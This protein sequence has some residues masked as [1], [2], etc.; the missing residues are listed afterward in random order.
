MQEVERL[1]QSRQVLVGEGGAHVQNERIRFFQRRRP[2]A[3]RGERRLG[4][5]Q[6]E[7]DLPGCERL[8]GGQIAGDELGTDNYPARFDMRPPEKQPVQR[9][10]QFVYQQRCCPFPD[11]PEHG[12]VVGGRD[13]PAEVGQGLLGHGEVDEIGT[14]PIEHP[15]ESQLVQGIERKLGEGAGEGMKIRARGLPRVVGLQQNRI[16]VF[17]VN[18]LQVFYEAVGVPSGTRTPDAG[19]D[20]NVFGSTHLGIIIPNNA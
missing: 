19:V 12:Q 1:D 20:D 11:E 13:D 14:E 7:R 9:G 17:G 15:G 8:V 16:A 5:L 18:L 10:L 3:G 6:C 2:F 4:R